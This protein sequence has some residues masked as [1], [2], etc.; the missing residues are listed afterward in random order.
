[1]A[2]KKLTTEEFIK[3]LNC[4]TILIGRKKKFCSKEC[5]IKYYAKN[6]RKTPILLL[7]ETH[8]ELIDTEWD[9]EKNNKLGLNPKKIASQSNKRA[10]WICKKNKEHKWDATIANRT[11]K[12]NETGCP[13]CSGRK[14][15]F[16]NCLSVI[17]PELSKEWNYKKNKN[18]R[19][20]NVVSKSQKKVWWVCLK[21]HEWKAT[22]AHRANG[23]NC[24]YCSGNKVC[25]DNCLLMINPKLCREW[26]YKKNKEI[27]PKNVTPGMNKQVWWVCSKGHEWKS[28]INSRTSGK[29]CPYCS[30]NKVCLEN[31]LLTRFPEIA[32]EWDFNRNGKLTPENIMP[33][34]IKKI[35]WI[36]NLNNQHKWK[37]SPN[38]RTNG[39]HGCPKCAIERTRKTTEEF[40]KDAIRVHGNKYNYSKVEYK[41]INS[42]III[43]CSIHGKYSQSPNGHLSGRGCSSCS[44]KG[45]GKIKE[46]L[47][48][49][50]K[51]WKI[52]PNKKIWSTYK[53]YKHRRFCDFWLE[54]DG[55]KII[56]EY[57]GAQHFKPVQFGGMSLKK[58]EKALKNYQLKDALDAEFCEENNIYLYRIKYDENKEQSIKELKKKVS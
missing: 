48:K 49:Y 21:G 23:S 1:M 44:N 47:L 10:F 13:Y 43:V 2:G 51:N 25:K 16:T 41:N 3:C 36:C 56:V 18:L 31:C 54:K 58:A 9:Y 45:E 24:P 6:N 39:K 33:G 52:I 15:N 40:I 29:N 22:I 46:F 7:Y 37:A 12:D 50:F 14:V 11:N 32:K 8:K 34:S 57:D 5:R 53:K 4:D 42:K 38:A 27:T 17:Y 19:P 35:W 26:N 55:V 20:E 30:G 28:T